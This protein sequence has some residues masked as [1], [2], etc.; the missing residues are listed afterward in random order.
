MSEAASAVSGQT[1]ELGESYVTLERVTDEIIKATEHIEGMTPEAVQGFVQQV[2]DL[3]WLDHAA[4]DVAG[5]KQ[6]RGAATFGFL[7]ASL[8]LMQLG[9]TFDLLKVVLEDVRV[10]QTLMLE[11]SYATDELLGQEE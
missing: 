9:A 5:Q 2:S 7:A 10:V 8:Q 11:L 6:Y 3:G 1:D 4:I